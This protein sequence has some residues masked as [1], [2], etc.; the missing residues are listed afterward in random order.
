[1]ALDTVGSRLPSAHLK[2]VSVLSFST[3]SKSLHWSL[4]ARFDKLDL[5]ST[6]PRAPITR[7]F[8]LSKNTCAS[9]AKLCVWVRGR[10]A[11]H[12]LLHAVIFIVMWAALAHQAT[13]CQAVCCLLTMHTVYARARVVKSFAQILAPLSLVL[14]SI[15]YQDS[16]RQPPLSYCSLVRCM[17]VKLPLFQELEKVQ[18]VFCPSDRITR[19]A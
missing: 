8:L 15:S 13:A 12:D 11:L 14:Q 18:F 9:T 17:S 6:H 10:R 7:R 1:M 3:A 19:E 16:H 2:R 4:R 5:V